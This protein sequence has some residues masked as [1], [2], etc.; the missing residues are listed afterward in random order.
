MPAP[1]S[2]VLTPTEQANYADGMI[3]T[4]RYTNKIPYL[5]ITDIYG[6]NIKTKTRSDNNTGYNFYFPYAISCGSNNYW[7]Y[8]YYRGYVGNIYYYQ[9]AL[10]DAQLNSCVSLGGGERML[11]SIYDNNKILFDFST[12]TASNYRAQSGSIGNNNPS[13]ISLVKNPSNSIGYQNGLQVLS[14]SNSN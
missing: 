4:V 8:D 11:S 12:T 1:L 7:D 14:N 9:S 5:K 10:S 6:G 13:L 3:I 2:I